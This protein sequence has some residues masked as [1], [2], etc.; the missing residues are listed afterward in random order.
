MWIMNRNRVDH[1]KKTVEHENENWVRK[2]QKQNKVT[3]FVT[4]IAELT[5][6]S[7]EIIRVD[8]G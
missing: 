2:K 1:V 5:K 8:Q 3:R 6:V 7:N 4:W